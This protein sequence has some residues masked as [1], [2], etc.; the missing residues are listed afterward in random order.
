MRNRNFKKTVASVLTG[1]M[2]VM[3][4]PAA[5]LAVYNTNL[6][7]IAASPGTQLSVGN[8]RNQYKE[9]NV[10]G[11]SYEIWIDTTG[12]SGSMTLGSGGAFNTNWNCQVNA[13]NFLARRGRN[14]DASKKATQY[15]DIVMNYAADY[16]A[17]S[18]GNSRLCVYGWF[19]N[20]LVEYYIIEDWVNWRPT[21][22]AK[23]VTVDGAEYEIF[24]LDHTGPTILGNTQTFKQYF[25]V[26]K[27]KRT[28]GTITVSDH[29]KAWANAGWNIGN[30]TEVALNVEGWESSGKA[31][32]SKL[33]IGS[34]PVPT[35]P[36][37]TAKPVEPASD[38]SY[39]KSSFESGKDGW[40]GRGDATVSVDSSNAASGSGC[41]KVTGRTDNWNGAAINLDTAAF[42]AGNTY[43]FS[44]GVMQK[45]GE[46]VDMK[47]TL[48]YSLSGEDHYDEVATATAANGAWTK[49]ENTAFTIPA[50]ATDMILYVE[51]PD[52][53]TDFYI[54]DA[55]GA[56]KGTKSTVKETQGSS[57]SQPSSQPSSQPTSQTQSSGQYNDSASRNFNKNDPGLKD[58]FSSYF[59]IGT[60]VSPHELNSG[61][62]FLKK[63]YNSITPEN[64]LKPNDLL[65]ESGCQQR[66]NGTNTQ[67]KL[68]SAAAQMK[69][70]Q[71]NGISMRGHTFVWYSQT[72]SW[73]FKDNFS[74]NGSYVSK[75]VMNKRLESMIKN[76][77][78]AVKTQYPK[79][80]LYSY[81]VCNELFQNDGG[82]FRGDGKESSDWWN[83]YKSDEFV[84]N[85][86]KY[87][88][89]Y[90]P[91]NCKLY[92]NDYNEYI[93]AKTSDIYNMAMKVKQAGNIDG[94]GMQSHLDVSY[95]SASVYK[96]ALQKFLSTG[97]DVQIT[98]LDITTSG[99]YTAQA[100]LYKDVFSMAMDNCEHIP[101]LT[102]WGTQDPVSWRSSQNPLLFS[103][104]YKPK[105]AYNAVI[106]LVP[107]NRIAVPK[108]SGSGA[109]VE[110]PTEAPTQKPTQAPTQAPS[111]TPSE[112]PNV[113]YG[114]ANGDGKVTLG[115]SLAVLQFIANS[116]K[117][118]LTDAQQD[119][120]DVY[121]R[122]DGITGMDSVSIQKYETGAI[123]KLPE[124]WKEG[125]SITPATNAPSTS[126]PTNT[127]S[128]KAVTA[129]FESGNSGWEERGSVSLTPDSDSYYSGSKSMLVSGRSDAWQGIAYNLDSSTYAPGSTFSFS[130]AVMQASGS[131]EDMKITLQYTLD[132][133]DNYDT[134][135][136]ATAKDKTW[137]KLENTAYTIPSGATNMIVYVE[138]DSSTTDFYVD[139]LMIAAEGTSSTVTTGGGKVNIKTPE[140]TQVGNVDP[141]KPMIAISFD[142]GASPSTG[143]RIVNALAKNGFRATF[144][145]VGD[146][147]KDSNGEQEIKNAYAKGMEIANHT[148]S[149]PHLP[150]LGGS[151]IRAE[152]DNTHAKLK[153]I[154]GAEPSKLMRL[155]YLESNG[156]VTSTLN[157]VALISCALDTQDWNGHSKDQIVNDIK[158]WVSSGQGNG[159]IVLCHETYDST[160]S[161]ME[162]VLPWIKAQGWQVVTIS[163]MFAAKGKKLNGGT[164]YTKV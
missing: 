81:D 22:N 74:R 146:W 145:Y 129:G 143:N 63:H 111:Q 156:T 51:A 62:S 158:G 53:L 20:P 95:P 5:P 3:S 85:A 103:S 67:V 82:G 162:E 116:S 110:T 101:A 27:Q 123:T 30:L 68:N 43:S 124:S 140:P 2:C 10:D 19:K 35:T 69:F 29:F 78:D 120:A 161:A 12:G 40:S 60:S 41:L 45:S 106:G 121:N 119:A 21:G 9:D 4:V 151:Q 127:S 77:F 34:D 52:S 163:D 96:T 86:F 159:A 23:T 132:G 104:G 148:T 18:Q 61:A 11:Y 76:T 150:Q 1:L 13:G 75:D 28:S 91:A 144:F 164:V 65:D 93:P 113:I 141:S 87:A 58:Y 66:G 142:D 160:A 6:T 109:I 47:L 88:R 136:S 152:F 137:T 46:A 99:N 157:D 83:V 128:V 49:L 94:I 155:P 31:N 42:Q 134:I 98:E 39:F 14:Y 8:G 114:D 108:S 135:A 72:P 89:Q 130:G 153:R 36:Q 59:K 115:D 122:G 16:S 79:L 112:N 102:I 139:D 55:M 133:E 54:D 131:A 38:G 90:A 138:T 84:L 80:D 15:G 92:I 100:N 125:A 44:T 33:T 73:F 154:I 70:C 50:G 149:H 56:V 48:Q 105:E 7:A 17:S 107:A 147:I 126:T 24:Q 25:S 97:L 57:D 118:P 117:Y 26:R 71:D 32:V 64:E 37:T